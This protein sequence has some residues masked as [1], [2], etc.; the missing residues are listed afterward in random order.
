MTD[1][2]GAT[3]I[4]LDEP[5][6]GQPVDDP[7]LYYLGSYLQAFINSNAAR[8]WAS[9]YPNA[10]VA[11]EIASKMVRVVHFANPEDGSP[12]NDNELPA[13]YIW[14]SDVTDSRAAD[15]WRMQE[16]RAELRWVFPRLL[17]QEVIEKLH[18]LLALLAKVVRV[19][20][21]RGRDVS[22]VVPN[23]PDTN[24]ATYGSVLVRWMQAA[25][26]WPHMDRWTRRPMLIGE[27]VFFTL[28]TS[29][30]F[31]ERYQLHTSDVQERGSGSQGTFHTPD[32]GYNDGGVPLGTVDLP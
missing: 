19:G 21:E 20:I 8:M 24:A 14:R 10:A 12:I 28:T 2:F 15:D 23:D 4:P 18:P 3:N 30:V 13:L 31:G 22:W 25:G 6:A 7:A 5:T 32:D 17:T 26:R 27:Q 16:S 9:L 29:V 1:S 11:P